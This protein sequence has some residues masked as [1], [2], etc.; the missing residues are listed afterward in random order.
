M[1]QSDTYSRCIWCSF[2]CILVAFELLDDVV[3]MFWMILSLFLGAKAP[4]G[5][6]SVKNKK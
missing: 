6:A 3:F 1:A 2:L 5:L 4:L